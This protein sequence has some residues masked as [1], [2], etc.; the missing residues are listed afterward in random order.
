MRPVLQTL[1]RVAALVLLT[2]GPLHA[3]TVAL[4]VGHLI[5]PDAGTSATNQV[6]LV[7]RG[8]ITAV[9]TDVEV[10]DGADVVDLTDHGCSPV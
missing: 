6:I 4:R 5:D 3:Q 9:G 10:P 8:R 2:A 7:E 1:G